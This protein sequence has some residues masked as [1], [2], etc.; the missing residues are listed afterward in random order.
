MSPDCWLLVPLG[1]PGDMRELQPIVLEETQSRGCFSPCLLASLTPPVGSIHGG[2]HR[3]GLPDARPMSSH[4]TGIP[5]R[6]GSVSSFGLSH[7]QDRSCP[8]PLD[9]N[10]LMWGV[11]WEPPE[12]RHCLPFPL[13]D[14]CLRPGTVPSPTHG[15]CPARLCWLE[16]PWLLWLQKGSHLNSQTWRLIHLRRPGA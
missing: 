1:L 4:Q 13:E 12:G 14:G 8:L 7:P 15:L 6:G 3:W 11:S 16:V 2:P 9:G 10:Y 5:L